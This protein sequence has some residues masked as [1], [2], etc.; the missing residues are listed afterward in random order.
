MQQ[1]GKLIGVGL[2]AVLLHVLS[3]SASETTLFA[4]DGAAVAYIADDQTIYLWSGDAVGYI[5]AGY[6]GD[7]NVYSSGGQHLGW[8][9]AGVLRDH[10]GRRLAACAGALSPLT[11]SEPAKAAK[12]PL[13]RQKFKS[14]PPIKPL[15]TNDW[16]KQRLDEVFK[17]GGC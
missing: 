1:S 14:T 7:L 15:F 10:E 4:A 11:G 16:A 13:E 2:F 6:S 17:Q 8:Y 9:G 5:E 12:K 3:T